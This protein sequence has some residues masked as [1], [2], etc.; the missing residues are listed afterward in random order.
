MSLKA[1]MRNMFAQIIGDDEIVGRIVTGDGV[2]V[3]WRARNRGEGWWKAE[4]EHRHGFIDKRWCLKR[5]LG[6]ALIEML[7]DAIEDAEA[8]VH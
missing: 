1:E 6:S 4:V 3:H 2:T 8:A 5:S 7:E